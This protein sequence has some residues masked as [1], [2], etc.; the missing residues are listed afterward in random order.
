VLS[1]QLPFAIVPL[2]RFTASHDIMGSFANGAAVKGL[3]FACAAL[4]IAAN[5]WLVGRLLASWYGSHPALAST[6]AVLALAALGLLACTALVPL[7]LRW[8][9]TEPEPA[10]PQLSMSPPG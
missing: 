8:N 7:R 1:L 3:A 9:R 4:V 10:A 2:I 5:A 6:F